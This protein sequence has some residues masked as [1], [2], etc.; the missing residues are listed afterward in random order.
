MLLYWAD[1]QEYFL[2]HLNM[3]LSRVFLGHPD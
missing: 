2:Q 3:P 1:A